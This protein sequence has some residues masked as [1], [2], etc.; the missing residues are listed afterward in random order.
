MKAKNATLKHALLLLLGG[1]LIRTLVLWVVATQNFRTV[2]RLLASPSDSF[3]KRL[4]VLP[5]EER[6]EILRHLS[7]E[8]NR[9]YFQLWNWTQLGLGVLMAGAG[10]Q[11]PLRRR[12]WGVLLA[13]VAVV[14]AFAVWLTPEIIRLGR[15]IDFSGAPAFEGRFGSLHF[16][17]VPM[18]LTKFLLGVFL[19]WD[20]IRSAQNSGTSCLKG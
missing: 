16:A 15:Q 11:T 14:G 8:L 5:P 4:S 6:R 13:M 10:T 1:W 19:A 2:D 20:L 17:Y 12:Q 3:Q 9:L 18:D 7:S